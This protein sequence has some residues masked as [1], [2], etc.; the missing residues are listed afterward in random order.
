M[1]AEAAK[2][3][4][5]KGILP[6]AKAYIPAADTDDSDDEDHGS[7]SSES[8]SEDE[9][10]VPLE[11]ELAP[12]VRGT[13]VQVTTVLWHNINTLQVGTRVGGGL[14]GSE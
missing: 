12:A 8:E 9:A 13:Q 6:G 1:E 5:R 14:T 10:L 7:G 3:M 4:R 2:R 11:L